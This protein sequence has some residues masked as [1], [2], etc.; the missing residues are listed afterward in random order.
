MKL[1]I[2]FADDNKAFRDGLR[3]LLEAQPGYQVVA[4]AVNGRE[5]VEKVSLFQ[6]DV[7][8]LDYSMPELDGLSAA[9]QIRKIDPQVKILMLTQ[10]DAPHT[11]QRATDVGAIGYV[12]KSDASRDLLLALESARQHKRFVSPAIS[13]ASVTGLE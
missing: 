4:E 13:G 6:P 2:L 8:I 12:V 7:V 5:A 9:T 3:R 1:R 11:V 10:H